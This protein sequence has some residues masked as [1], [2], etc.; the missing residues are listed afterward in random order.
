MLT[1]GETPPTPHRPGAAIQKLIPLMDRYLH[2]H[3]KTFNVRTPAPGA[4]SIAFQQTPRCMCVAQGEV[5][6]KTKA[7]IE[8]GATAEGLRELYQTSTWGARAVADCSCLVVF[9]F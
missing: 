6:R 4:P 9:L 3:H 2:H 1:T 5:R 7:L 8:L